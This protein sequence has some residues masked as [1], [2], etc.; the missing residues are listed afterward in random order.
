MP[1][2]TAQT[3]DLLV[4]PARLATFLTQARAEQQLS[5]SDIELRAKG[6]FSQGELRQLEAGEL[7]LRDPDLRLLAS[8]YG[9]D[10]STIVP[11]RAALVIDRNE[12]LVSLGESVGQFKPQDD[13]RKIMLRY[14][15]LVYRIRNAQPGKLI[16][17]RDDDL[18]VLATVFGATPAEI[19]IQ[20]E[21][22]MLVAAPQIRFQ[23]GMFRNRVIIPAL[24][25]LVALTAAGGLVLTSGGS[26]SITSAA[27]IGSAITIERSSAK[28]VAST[29]VANAQAP[30]G[31]ETNIGSALTIER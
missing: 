8:A 3:S 11:T 23:H 7:A 1:V 29:V 9:I 25:V 6:A 21:Q 19:R 15:A 10:W 22:L 30:V 5:I 16:A 31:G 4:P 24:G 13:D 20:L 26:S 14:L 27:N 28:T 12:G 18:E 2:A 17:S